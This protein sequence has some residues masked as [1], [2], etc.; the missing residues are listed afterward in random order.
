MGQVSIP[1]SWSGADRYESYVGR[2]SRPVGRR[3][4]AWLA[5]AP[6]QRWI[7]VGCGTG[8]LTETIVGDAEPAE[9]VGIDPSP[10]FLAAAAPRVTDP[11]ASFRQGSAQSLP[12]DDASAEVLVSGLVLNFV[13]DPPAAMAEMRRVAV[14]GGIV[15]AYVWDYAGGMQLM[16]RFWTAAGEL[17]PA[18]RSLDEGLRFSLCRPDALRQLFGDAGLTDVAVEGIVVPTVFADFDDYWSPFL[19][20]TGPAPAYAVSLPEAERAAL[21]ETLRGRLPVESDGSIHLTARAW[22]VRGRVASS[23]ADS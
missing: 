13:P 7:D 17:D 21:R 8:A 2:W 22:A 4:L 18:A 14:P 16:Q 20:G 23:H 12:L 3:F 5:A 11:R 10:D 1:S 15:A 9:V 19:G 6:D